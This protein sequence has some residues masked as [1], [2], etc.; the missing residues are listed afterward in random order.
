MRGQIKRG[1]VHYRIWTNCDSLGVV[2][3]LSL[4]EYLD[5]VAL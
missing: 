5:K 3:G 2:K 4:L 1:A